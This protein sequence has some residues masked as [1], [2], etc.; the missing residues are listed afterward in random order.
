MAAAPGFGQAFPL[1]NKKAPESQADLLAIQN[2]L[3]A[4]IPK[5]KMATVCIDL[6][7]GTGSGVI[8]SAD[9]LVMTAAHVSTGVG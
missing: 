1:N 6:G 9:G 4:A 5:A 3:H 7:D 8:V 2:A